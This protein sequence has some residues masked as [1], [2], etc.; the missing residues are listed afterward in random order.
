MNRLKILLITTALITGSSALASAQEHY[1]TG[2]SVQVR[3]GG[4]DGE[5]RGGFYAYANG[6]HDRDNR[7]VDRDDRYRG[8][9]RDDRRKRDDDDRR[10]WN[11]N[12]DGD[13][14]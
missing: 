3:V 4:H 11:Y 12:H 9:D 7:Y 6:D 5:N 10:G 8:R 2:F 13:R 14:R 1:Q